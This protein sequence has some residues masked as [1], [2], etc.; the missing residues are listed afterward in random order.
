M[1]PTAQITKQAV[2]VAMVRHIGRDQGVTAARLVYEMLGRFD[3]EAE[4][5]LRRVIVEL[6]LEGQHI[7]GLPESG[8]SMAE[9]SAE[10]SAGIRHLH[11]RAMTS[12][13]QAYAMR[14]LAMPDLEGQLRLPT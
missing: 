8:Y 12:L 13:R 14:G 7:C 4:R 9:N 2:L 3:P 10:L 1:I 5:R 11:D 6:R